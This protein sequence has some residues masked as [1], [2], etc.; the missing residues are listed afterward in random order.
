MRN[1]SLRTCRICDGKG[2]VEVL[3][4]AEEALRKFSQPK[5]YTVSKEQ[6]VIIRYDGLLF[7]E[8][9]TALQV[10]KV[11]GIRAQIELKI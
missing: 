1:G 7:D 9:Y 2:V 10:L 11:S 8:A 3:K 5:V 6:S 4:L